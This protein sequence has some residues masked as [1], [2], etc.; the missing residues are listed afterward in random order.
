MTANDIAGGENE[1]ETAGKSK[2]EDVKRSTPTTVKTAIT[3]A[4]TTILDADDKPASGQASQTWISV[5]QAQ[6]HDVR[7][8]DERMT[9]DYQPT[10]SGPKNSNQISDDDYHRR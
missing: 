9:A 6:I 2:E 1:D 8:K 7:T 10:M 5:S 4:V 3:S